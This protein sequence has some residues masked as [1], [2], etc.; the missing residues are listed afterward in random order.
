VNT[1][2]VTNVTKQTTTS[3]YSDW[4]IVWTKCNH[5]H[6]MGHTTTNLWIG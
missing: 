5:T 6:T 2:C 4:E 1:G 3:I